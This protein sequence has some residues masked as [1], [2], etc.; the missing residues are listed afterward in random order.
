MVYLRALEAEN[1]LYKSCGWEKDY[2]MLSL[3]QLWGGRK[4]SRALSLH[5]T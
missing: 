4:R 1:D 5:M 3:V 2:S